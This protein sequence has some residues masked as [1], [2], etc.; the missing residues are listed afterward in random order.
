LLSR[1]VDDESKQRSRQAARARHAN[2]GRAAQPALWDTPE[3]C[4]SADFWGRS[5]PRLAAD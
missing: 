3:L 1:D 4:T 5:S 2:L